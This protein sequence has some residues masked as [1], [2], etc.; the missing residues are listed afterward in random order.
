MNE[1]NETKPGQLALYLKGDLA[2][3]KR[4]LY[5]LLVE[6]EHPVRSILSEIRDS[7]ERCEK[8]IDRDLAPFKVVIEVSGGVA[9]CTECSEGV[10]VEIV[11]HDNLKAEVEDARRKSKEGA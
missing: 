5:R 11:D 4:H 1:P 6:N 2:P 7:I 9:E 8:R 3:A 10:T